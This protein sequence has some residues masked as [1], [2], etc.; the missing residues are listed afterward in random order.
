MTE[1]LPQESRIEI[2]TDPI[3]NSYVLAQWALE[4]LDEPDLTSVNDLGAFR[5]F[6]VV[7]NEGGKVTPLAVVIFN[8]F[9]ELPMGNDMR[10]IVAAESPK[11]CLPGV[12]RELFR[13]PFEVAGCERLTSTI[14]D[15]NNRSLRLTKGLGFKKEGTL[16]R[17]HDGKTNTIV[18]GMLKH[19]CKWL[20]G[21]RKHERNNGQEIFR[22]SSA[23]SRSSKNRRR[24]K[25]RRQR[26]ANNE[27]AD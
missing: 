15:G 24:A 21:P 10:V 25:R 11:W 20:N 23:G 1:S 7:R 4:R 27:R 16:R 17:A 18:L 13:Y 26:R 8:Y 5:A 6:G 12:L 22:E 19:E 2:V 9:R 3:A 14:R